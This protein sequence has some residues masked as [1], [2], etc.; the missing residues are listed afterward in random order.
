MFDLARQAG[1]FSHKDRR[2][3]KDSGNLDPLLLCITVG[4]N[5]VHLRVFSAA[6]FVELELVLVLEN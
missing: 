1:E 5:L 6:L 3:H 4:K 2:D